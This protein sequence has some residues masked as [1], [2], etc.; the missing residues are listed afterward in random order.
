MGC[1]MMDLY[2][3]FASLA[4]SIR[5]IESAYLAKQPTMLALER[6]FLRFR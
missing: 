6:S 1:L 5:G 4:I 3:G 2:T